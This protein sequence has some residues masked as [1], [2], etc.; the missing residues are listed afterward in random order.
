MYI[1]ICICTYVHESIYEKISHNVEQYGQKS[2]NIKAKIR[3]QENQSK[4]LREGPET[5]KGT[6]ST[7]ILREIFQK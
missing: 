1:F 4:R 7:V 6:N 2:E 3:N 5:E